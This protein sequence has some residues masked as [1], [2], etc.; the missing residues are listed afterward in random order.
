MRISLERDA[1]LV[2]KRCA[3]RWKMMRISLEDDAHLVEK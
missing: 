3:S 1:H 2:V